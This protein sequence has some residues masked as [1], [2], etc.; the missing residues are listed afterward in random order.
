VHDVYRQWRQVADSYD[1]PKVFVAE[2]WVDEPERLARYL[3]RDELH[4]AFNFTYLQ[5]TWDADYLQHVITETLEEQGAVG[6]PATWVLSNHDVVRHVSRFARNRTEPGSH[7]ESFADLPVDLELGRRRSR[8]ALLLTLGLPG[9]AYVYQGEELGLPEVEDLPTDALQDPVWERSGHTDRGRDGCRVPLPW[10]G[11]APPYGFGPEGAADPWLPQPED[12]AALTVDA[13]TGDPTSMLELYRAALRLRRD[14]E[15]LGDGSL[16][17]LDL[18]EGVLGFTRD[19]GFACLVNVSADP[20][21]LPDGYAVLLASE[22]LADGLLPRD[23]S[24]W[25]TRS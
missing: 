13:E 7:L 14:T 10:S 11:T 15:A 20:Q 12:W 18:P 21:P 2:A 19:P 22:P 5:T 23:T 1:D 17:W 8:A 24:V 16:A 25:L 3:R 4:T 6:A 9:G